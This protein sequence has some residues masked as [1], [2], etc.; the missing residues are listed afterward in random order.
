[1]HRVSRRIVSTVT[2]IAV[3]DKVAFT[4]DMDQ[5][6]VSQNGRTLLVRV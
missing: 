3:V 2:S 5:G 1:V 6:V 4:L